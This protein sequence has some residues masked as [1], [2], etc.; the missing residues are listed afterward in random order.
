LQREELTSGNGRAVV[1]GVSIVGDV[2]VVAAHA[3]EVGTDG[4]G[5]IAL[6][7]GV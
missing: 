2:L 1:G 7:A 3:R 6:T 5:E 4:G